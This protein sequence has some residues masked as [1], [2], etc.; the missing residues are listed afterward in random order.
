MDVSKT[1]EG[2]GAGVYGYDTEKKL[3]SSLGQYT[4]V[5]QAEVHVI[6]A[7][8]VENIKTGYK[9]RNIYI[10]PEAKAAIK[11]LP[12]TRLTLNL[13]LLAVCHGTG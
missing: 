3:S 9:N 1:N 11:H 5:F 4:T 6:K 10:L 13:G 8:A 2:T 7:C 12:N